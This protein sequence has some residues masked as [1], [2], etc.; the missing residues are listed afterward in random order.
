MRT[1]M[2]VLDADVIT[3]SDFNLDIHIYQVKLRY[4]E[5]ITANVR[6]LFAKLLSM[7]SR[8]TSMLRAGT[9]TLRS[10]EGT[11]LLV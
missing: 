3:C 7:A 2:T 1:R 6:S 11:I 10:F 5:Q 8:P 9:H 4:S